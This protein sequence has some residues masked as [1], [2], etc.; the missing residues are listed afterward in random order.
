MRDPPIQP[1][2]AGYMWDNTTFGPI[3][4]PAVSVLNSFT[5]SATQQA[6]SVV[7]D[8]NPQCYEYPNPALVPPPMAGETED[9]GAQTVYGQNTG[10]YS[11]YGVEYTPGFDDAYIDWWSGEKLAWTLLVQGLG[12]DEATAI[13]PRAVSQEP[14]VSFFSQPAL[15]FSNPPSSP[16]ADVIARLSSSVSHCQPRH[17]TQLWRSRPGPHTV[18]GAHED[19]LDTRLPAIRRDQRGMRPT[20]FPDREVHRA[21]HGRVH[22]RELYDV[23]GGLRASVAWELVPWTV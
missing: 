10:C 8:T 17:V 9:P 7:T 16:H 15:F 21:V 5:G 3:V 13:G 22:G 18:P 1:F 23:D 2:D 6:T 19:R 12:A 20:G 4:D 14:M 11:V